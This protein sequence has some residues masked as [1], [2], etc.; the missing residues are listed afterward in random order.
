M[1]KPDMQHYTLA[2]KRRYLQ[3]FHLASN[4]NHKFLLVLA[5]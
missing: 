1:R 3:L 2:L 5:I 4:L